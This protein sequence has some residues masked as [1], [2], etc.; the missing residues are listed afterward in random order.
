VGIDNMNTY[1]DVQLKRD[2]LGQLQKFEEFS[3]HLV[4]IADVKELHE[5]LAHN[6][7]D[8]V[9][10]LAAQAGVRYSLEH[11]EAYVWSNLVG[12][13]NL[14]QEC[15]IDNVRHFIYASSSSVYGVNEHSPFSVDDRVDHPISLYA[16]TK[17]AD[18]LI[19]HAYSHLFS[20][21]T[22]GLRF[23]TVYGPWGRPDMA[24]FLF[25]D[26]I[27]RG[28]P[29]TLFNGGEMYRD[30]T[31]VDDIVEAVTR[32][33]PLVPERSN[34]HAL[35][36]SPSSSTASF[37]IYNIGHGAPVRVGDC[38]DLIEE[39]LSKKAVRVSAPMQPGDVVST[40][41]DTESLRRDVGFSPSIPIGVGIPRFVKWYLNYYG[42]RQ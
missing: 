38:V 2:R 35:L 12:F 39:C 3:F 28:M 14:V 11:P 23:F 31:Y 27:F 5:V 10:H 6:S 1:Y 29:V 8:A 4:D 36:D 22:T 17:R 30:F 42:Q 25:T 32:V 16:A 26:A 9:I 21:P 33:I 18:E 15:R 34:Q 19:A 13:A 37:R 41:A 7:Y 24:L 40:H 20:L